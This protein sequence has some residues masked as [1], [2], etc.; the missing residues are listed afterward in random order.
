MSRVWSAVSGEGSI[1]F[2]Q[3]PSSIKIESS[4]LD[5]FV[6]Q[7]FKVSDLTFATLEAIH[8]LYLYKRFFSVTCQ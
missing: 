5:I 2:L 3:R 6:A 8:V 4:K 7:F 1:I